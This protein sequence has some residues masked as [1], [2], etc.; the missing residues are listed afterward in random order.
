MS[1]R[2]RV[3]IGIV[4]VALGLLL[5]LFVLWRQVYPVAEPTPSPT[6]E[7]TA[8]QTVEPV[9]D[10]T[11]EPASATE[12]DDGLVDGLPVGKL[13][14]TPERKAYVDGSLSIYIPAINITRTIYDGTDTA[15]LKKGVGLYDY[16]Q[17]PGE[18][19]RNVSMAGHR[20][21]ISNGKITDH[22]PFYYIDKLGAGD[23]LYLRDAE[24]IYRYLW[25]S[26]TV[27]EPDDWSPIYTT[28]YSCLTITSCTPIG[29]SDHRIVVRA[30]LDKIFDYD[31]DFQYLE[32][33]QES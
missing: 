17:L 1:K 23:Y 2:S 5:A 13:V 19:N 10:S 15:T 31:K 21:G 26:C 16:A 32:K 20:N 33:E 27:V 7:A 18:G 11:P 9:P 22:A 4:L 3:I 29:I 30:R 6:Q 8:S 28:G 14:I 12:P 24:H 25:E